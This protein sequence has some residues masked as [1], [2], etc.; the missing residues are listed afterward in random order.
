MLCDIQI[1]VYYL[2]IAVEIKIIIV[3]FQL[4]ISGG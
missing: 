3:I 2:I 4:N 1:N